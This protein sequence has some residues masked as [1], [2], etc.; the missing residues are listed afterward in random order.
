MLLKRFSLIN[1]N[2]C[3]GQVEEAVFEELENP[4]ILDFRNMV[5]SNSD[6]WL[7]VFEKQI[8]QRRAIYI[9]QGTK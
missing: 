6:D 3:H 5:D 2:A 1:S 8:Y 4:E 7:L 9:I